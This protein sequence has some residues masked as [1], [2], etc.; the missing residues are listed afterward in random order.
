MD[1]QNEIEELRAESIT[2][3]SELIYFS[4][5]SEVN[6]MINE[7]GLDLK[8]SRVPPIKIK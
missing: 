7:K 2:T 4:K 8:E 5:R 1:L 3:A 6:K